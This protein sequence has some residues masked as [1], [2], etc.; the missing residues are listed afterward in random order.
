MYIIVSGV[1]YQDKSPTE[2]RIITI[3]VFADHRD[4]TLSVTL[5]SWGKYLFRPLQLRN[6]PESTTLD[7]MYL[8]VEEIIDA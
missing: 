8:V 1:S 6:E 3:G 5:E 7:C 2:K 4:K